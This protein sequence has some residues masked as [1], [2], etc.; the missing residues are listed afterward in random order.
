MRRPLAV[1]L[2]LGL[3][4]GGIVAGPA[5]AKKKKKKPKRV[6]RT[7]ET[8][9]TFPSGIGTAGAGACSGCVQ[10]AAGPGE[11][12]VSVE[13]QDDT[14]P[15]AGADISWDSDGDGLNDTGFTVCGATDGF[16][17]IPDGVTMV[18]FTWIVTGPGCPGGGATSGTIKAT[19]AN[20]P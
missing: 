6:E 9:Y 17:E 18:A 7:V 8:S 12:W 16:V 2:A 11:R 5:E 13:L 19:F 10:L 15:I 4:A 1:L 3:L 20:K 14:L